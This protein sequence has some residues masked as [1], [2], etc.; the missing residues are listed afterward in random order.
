MLGLYIHIPFCAQKCYY[1]DF[2]SYKIKNNNEKKEYISNLEK[3]INMY[4]D[5]F[6]NKSFTSLFLGGGTP[7]IL[8]ENEI[9]EIMKN[10]YK[11]FDIDRD[12]EIT[13]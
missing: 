1:C 10:I 9:E 13:I 8:N 4:K 12:A 7:S 6:K 11:N 2:N 3:E 5:E